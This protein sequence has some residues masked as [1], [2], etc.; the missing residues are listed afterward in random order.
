[1]IFG[2]IIWSAVAVLIVGIGIRSWTSKK[3]AGISSDSDDY[4]S[5]EKAVLTEMK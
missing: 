3:P 5:P 1:M 2:V 4:F